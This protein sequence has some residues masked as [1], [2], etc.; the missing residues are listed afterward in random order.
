MNRASLLNGGA[1]AAAVLA[2]GYT[3]ATAGGAGDATEAN[4]VWLDRKVPNAGLAMSAKV[5]ISYEAALGEGNTLKFGFNLQDATSNAGAGADDYGDAYPS[6]VVATG[7]AG[8]STEK[9]TVEFDIDLAGANEFIRTQTT[10]D[11]SAANTDTLKYM[12]TVVFFGA[13]NQP[14]SKAVL[15]TG[16]PK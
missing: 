7:G 2:L 16:G 12:V 8:G 11:L 13:D 14:M 6:T 1:F 4:G 10:P 15:A 5:I 3:A 9:G